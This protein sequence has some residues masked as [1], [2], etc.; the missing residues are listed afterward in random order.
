[1][2]ITTFPKKGRVSHEGRRTLGKL[3]PRLLKDVRKPFPLFEFHAANETVET[4]P[5][6]ENLY[7]ASLKIHQV[8]GCMK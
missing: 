4:S 3:D 2:T 8:Q 6:T 5:L 1:M 7:T